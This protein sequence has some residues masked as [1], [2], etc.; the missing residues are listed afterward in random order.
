MLLMP[1][2]ITLMTAAADTLHADIARG[3]LLA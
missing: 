3:A 1:D 2:Y